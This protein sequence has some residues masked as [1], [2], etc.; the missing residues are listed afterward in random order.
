MDNPVNA[1]RDI[2]VDLLESYARMPSVGAIHDEVEEQLI[3]DTQRDH[4]QM[5]VGFITLFFT[6]I[7]G[8]VK[9]GCRKT[10]R[11]LI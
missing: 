1:Y 11:T 2:I 9:F 4:Y 8:M 3:L 10:P 6:L 7:F 5:A